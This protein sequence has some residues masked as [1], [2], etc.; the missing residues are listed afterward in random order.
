MRKGYEP[1]KLNM[2]LP[3]NLFSKTIKINKKNGIKY[4]ILLHPAWNARFF[5]PETMQSKVSYIYG[6]FFENFKH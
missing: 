1:H 6:K 5:V 2:D 4:C 3:K